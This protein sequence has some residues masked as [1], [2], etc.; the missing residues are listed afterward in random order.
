MTVEVLGSQLWLK[1]DAASGNTA[2]P[3]NRFDMSLS[4]MHISKGEMKLHSIEDS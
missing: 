4:L 2:W 3:T 1:S